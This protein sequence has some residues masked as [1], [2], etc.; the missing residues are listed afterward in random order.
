M[1]A[2]V[3]VSVGFLFSDEYQFD[4]FFNVGKFGNFL[5]PHP[6]KNADVLNGWFLIGLLLGL[7]TKLFVGLE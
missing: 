6:L 7:S 3:H 4:N 2:T 5:T 1:F